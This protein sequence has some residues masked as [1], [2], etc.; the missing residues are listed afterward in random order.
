MWFLRPMAG[1]TLW[2]KK[3]CSDIRDHASQPY[4]TTAN[5]IVLYILIFKFL[6]GSREDKSAW[7][8]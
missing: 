1:Y 2:N 6:G 5:V 7:T 8:E 4:S 3:I